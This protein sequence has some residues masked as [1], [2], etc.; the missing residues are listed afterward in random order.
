MHAGS[1]DGIG[2]MTAGGANSTQQIES[3]AGGAE[4]LLVPKGLRLVA[5][6]APDKSRT[7]LV[8]G[9]SPVERSVEV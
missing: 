4:V 3:K 1:G 8:R 7:K 5:R 9:Q 2:W 6:D